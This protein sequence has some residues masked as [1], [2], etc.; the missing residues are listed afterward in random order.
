ME[1]FRPCVCV[2]FILVCVNYEYCSVSADEQAAVRLRKLGASVYL[3]SKGA[4]VVIP[5][6]RTEW[7]GSKDDL[8]LLTQLGKVESLDFMRG[9][10]KLDDLD[11]LEV[12]PQIEGLRNLTIRYAGDVSLTA[13]R[14]IAKCKH[15]KVLNLG[16]CAL[17]VEKAET[18][19]SL[20]ELED[21][22]LQE[23]RMTD[24]CVTPILKMKSLRRLS[25]VS[26][27]LTSESL[28][29][30]SELENLEDLYFAWTPLD[31]GAL[32]HLIKLKALRRFQSVPKMISPEDLPW[33]KQQMPNCKF[34]ET[35]N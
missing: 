10:V 9:N 19:S 23:L 18:I 3:E 33:I 8:H 15:L 25:L 12:L 21:L 34:E 24:D 4:V 29:A 13:Y 11:E 16:S 5:Y 28:K 31:H 17:T 1:L 30:V 2:A 6:H 20:R 32:Q 7:T 27:K 22:A 26:F 35:G 14:N